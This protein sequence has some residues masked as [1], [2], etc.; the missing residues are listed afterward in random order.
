MCSA[1]SH[2]YLCNPSGVSRPHSR[3][4]LSRAER[5]AWATENPIGDPYGGPSYGERADVG[6]VI[7]AS[8]SIVGGMDSQDLEVIEA[9]HIH[10]EHLGID[11]DGKEYLP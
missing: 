10:P 8:A 9:E 11:L 2:R 6:S 3:V 4:Y 7:S 1:I 5:R